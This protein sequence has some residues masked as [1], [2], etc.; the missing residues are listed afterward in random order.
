M[1]KL[2]NIESFVLKAAR[3]LGM[4][5]M[6]VL[7]LGLGWNAIS[8]VYS[9]IRPVFNQ[10]YPKLEFQLGEFKKQSATLESTSTSSENNPSDT[11]ADK[12]TKQILSTMKADYEET[13]RR[14]VLVKGINLVRGQMSEE[15]KALPYAELEQSQEAVISDTAPKY[16]NLFYEKSYPR[17]KNDLLNQ[18]YEEEFQ[19]DFSEKLI[20]YMKE[21]ANQKY[22]PYSVYNYQEEEVDFITDIKMSRVYKR[23]LE[24]Y[25]DEKNRLAAKNE[26]EEFFTQSRLIFIGISMLL[27]PFLG[28]LFSIMRI[29]KHIGNRS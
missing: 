19:E 11:V 26:I 5:F 7:V 18:F 25:I 23:F 20:D 17:I 3:I 4:F 16:W 29:E 1:I 14:L 24:N 28:V 21:S 22:S 10:K 2:E 15:L 8:Y 27:L 12:L 13:V 6:L 9:K